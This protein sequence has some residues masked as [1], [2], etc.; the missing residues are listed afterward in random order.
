MFLSSKASPAVFE[1]GL[2]RSLDTL[3]T[4]GF[5]PGLLQNPYSS[6]T[7]PAYSAQGWLS[8]LR[9][10]LQCSPAERCFLQHDPERLSFMLWD[11]QG[12]MGWQEDAKSLVKRVLEIERPN[13][14]AASSIVGTVLGMKGTIRKRLGESCLKWSRTETRSNRTIQC[15]NLLPV[16]L[17]F[18]TEDIFHHGIY[19][20][21]SCKAFQNKQ[22]DSFTAIS[23]PIGSWAQGDTILP[24]Y[25]GNM[26]QKPTLTSGTES[27]QWN[28]LGE[29]SK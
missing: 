14:D 7:W 19:A 21:K 2:H 28:C 26:A 5:P 27:A 8:E 22:L 3:H 29:G 1:S 25:W 12:N 17:S 13:L 15:L 18:T 9:W 10:A 6:G 23:Q 24:S 11:V 4:L 16:P 20:L